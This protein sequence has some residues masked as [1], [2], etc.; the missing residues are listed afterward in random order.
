MVKATRKEA[1]TTSL[2]STRSSTKN[3]TRDPVLVDNTDD[4]EENVI[5]ASSGKK[6]NKE[7]TRKEKGS[8]DSTA[9]PFLSDSNIN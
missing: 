7:P 1:P 5:V 9:I 8:A 2:R 6:A 3:L 4:Q